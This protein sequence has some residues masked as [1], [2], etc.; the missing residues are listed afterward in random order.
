MENSTNNSA[1]ETAPGKKPADRSPET[2]A[3]PE[4]KEKPSL[5]VWVLLISAAGIIDLAQVGIDGITFMTLGPIINVIIDIFVG[6]TLAFIY[7]K[8]GIADKVNMIILIGGFLVDAFTGGGLPAWS[9]EIAVTWLRNSQIGAAAMNIPAVKEAA[10]AL[11]KGRGKTSGAGGAGAAANLGTTGGKS[12]NGI[13]PGTGTG[14]G[15]QRTV[16]PPGGKPPVLSPQNSTATQNK[17]S[18]SAGSSGQAQHNPREQSTPEQ[19]FPAFSASSGKTGSG[20]KSKTEKE[21][22]DKKKKEEQ[23]KNQ[24][25]KSGG[26]F[27]PM[28]GSHSQNRGGSSGRQGTSGGGGGGGEQPQNPPRYGVDE[29]Y[30]REHP[31]LS[32]IDTAIGVKEKDK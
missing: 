10:A 2:A 28:A 26:G 21:D 7:Y 12:I 6:I 16:A 5:A 13:K 27:S 18:A 14:N 19:H 22:E 20:G 31:F 3:A 17:T 9:L 8:I 25:Q 29:N 4:K 24:Q 32:G 1:P 23:N 15:T 11:E 30:A